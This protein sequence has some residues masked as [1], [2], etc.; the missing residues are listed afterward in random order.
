[1]A[2]ISLVVLALVC[3]A[4]AHAAAAEQVF[5][6]FNFALAPPV[7]N[8]W[9]VHEAA[10]PRSPKRVQAGFVNRETGR[11][12]LIEV[13]KADPLADL[14]DEEFI[15]EAERGL[16]RAVPGLRDGP[17]AYEDF[18]GVPALEAW[19]SGRAGD[20][21]MRILCLTFL[22]DGRLYCLSATSP[23]EGAE[24]D[25][26]L[27]AAVSGFRFLESPS[28]EEHTDAF[29]TGYRIGYYVIPAVIVVA[30]VAFVRSLRRRAKA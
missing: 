4:V 5:P 17:R 29:R 12:V 15:D 11:A 7:G 27:T 18:A 28:T 30:I 16:R 2:R 9:Q 19:F 22:A 1:M 3:L 10:M 25:A 6:D 24:V 13:R 14:H 21:P 20:R 26:A 8:G 23:G